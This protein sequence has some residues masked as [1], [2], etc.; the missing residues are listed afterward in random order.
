MRAA[1]AET[2]Q[3]HVI[4]EAVK[5]Q[6]IKLEW[7]AITRYNKPGFTYFTGGNSTSVPSI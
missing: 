3:A 4:E 1:G 6:W 7:Y 2:Q 5:E